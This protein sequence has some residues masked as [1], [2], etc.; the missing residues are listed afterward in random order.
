MTITLNDNFRDA[1]AR[2]SVKPV[3]L[4]R[5]RTGITNTEGVDQFSFV[6]GDKPLFG[7]SQTVSA[8]NPVASQIDIETRRFSLDDWRIDFLNS[9]YFRQLMI[10]H[11]LARKPLEIYRGEQSLDE[12]DF[13][14][15]ARTVIKEI[16][17]DGKVISVRAFT[18]IG[19]LEEQKF[20]GSFVNQ[21]PLECMEALL[22]AANVP[23]EMYDATTLDPSDAAYSDISH[24]NVTR[25][26]IN[27]PDLPQGENAITGEISTSTLMQELMDLLGGSFVPDSS[28]V[29]RFQLFDPA[30]GIERTL[31]NDDVRG[32]D[33]GQ[34]FGNIANDWTIHSV[35][36]SVDDEETWTRF[37]LQDP[38]SIS[39]HAFPGQTE[40]RFDREMET[41][42]VNGAS[43]LISDLLSTDGAGSF[44]TLRWT[45]IQGFSGAR[46]PP[47]FT[48]PRGDLTPPSWAQASA[49]R[50]VYIMLS[51]IW[52]NGFGTEIIECDLVETDP[53]FTD[54]LGNRVTPY[55]LNSADPLE[56][57]PEFVRFRISARAQYG[58][59]AR[60]FSGHVFRP[61]LTA[62]FD[63][64]I[65]VHM[66]ETRLERFTNGVPLLDI[67]TTYEHW[68]L[69]VGDHIGLTDSRPVY[70]DHD[71]SGATIWEIIKREERFD[72]MRFLLAR[73]QTTVVGT[74][75]GVP[76]DP[77]QDVVIPG[78][79]ADNNYYDATGAVY[80]DAGGEIYTTN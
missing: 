13:I 24:F 47:D 6:T 29:Y 71:G 42:W 56:Y 10:D 1:Y 17:T 50:P 58:T 69:Q 49:S 37:Q 33:Q 32:V 70:F 79:G 38:D 67:E 41:L 40:G 53:A 27:I 9:G 36:R 59:S 14:L 30:Q 16:R 60:S 74:P 66:A 57:Y 43:W 78:G 20:Q 51:G 39:G 55:H 65:P 44:F 11:R 26:R 3:F 62:G 8:V 34:T 31:T 5:I 72:H 4:I 64:T 77:P 45:G 61:I 80:M 73:V 68:D 12:A 15:A 19:L 76:Y 52:F 46:Y 54:S 2:E 22:V 18:A 48:Q 63:V 28:Q 21:H 23:T 25:A 35:R 75:T 7:Y